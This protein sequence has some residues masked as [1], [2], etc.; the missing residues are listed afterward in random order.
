VAKA[1]AAEIR[2]Q[3]GLGIGLL[4]SE[5]DFVKLAPGQRI[6]RSLT[7]SP[8]YLRALREPGAVSMRGVYHYRRPESPLVDL[9]ADAWEGAVASESVEIRVLAPLRR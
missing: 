7:V 3:E 1:G 2:G 9:P 6:T 8:D 4:I 5:H